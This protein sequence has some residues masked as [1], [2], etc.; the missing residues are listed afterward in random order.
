MTTPL[1][2]GPC[3]AAGPLPIPTPGLAWPTPGMAP[4]S[5][6]LAA[7]HTPP[8]HTVTEA[9][10]HH[11]SREEKKAGKINTLQHVCSGCPLHP[12]LTPAVPATFTRLPGLVFPLLLV[13]S[14]LPAA[15]IVARQCS[16]IATR[17]VILKSVLKRLC[18]DSTP[19]FSAGEE[20]D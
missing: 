18:Q 11:T 20:A 6:H 7:L 17:V 2:S 5:P 19:C 14:N 16:E 10:L 15:R 13:N 12:P 9:S 3:G 4:Q 8:H 1:P